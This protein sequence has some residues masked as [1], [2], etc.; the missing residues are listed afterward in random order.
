MVLVVPDVCLFPGSS[1]PPLIQYLGPQLTKPSRSL[2]DIQILSYCM[3]MLQF[4]S[5]CLPPSY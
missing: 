5:Q 2:G 4:T 1:Q 3:E